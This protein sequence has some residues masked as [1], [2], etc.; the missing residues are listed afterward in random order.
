MSETSGRPPAHNARHVGRLPEFHVVGFSGHRHLADPEGTAGAIHEALAHLRKLI[1]GEWIALSSIARGGDQ[2]FV[3][4]ARRMGLSWHAI[5][6]LAR[7]EFASDFTPEE[8]TDVEKS[9]DT[10]DHVHV[11]DENGDRKDSYLDCGIETVNGSDVLLAVWDGDPARGKGGTAEVVEYARSIGKP[12]VILDPKTLE[13]RRENWDRLEPN[14][15]VLADLNA[16]PDAKSAWAINPFKAPAEVFLFQQK[17]DYH[18]THDAPQ[19]RRLIVATVMAHVLASLVGATVVAYE[20]HSALLALLEL[21]CISFALGAA[22]ALRHKMHSHHSWVRCRLAAEFCRSA[23]ATW[24]LPRAAPLLQDLDVAGARGLTRTLYVMH[25]RSSATRPVP[26]EEFKRIYLEKRVDDQLAYYDRQVNRA[27]PLYKRLAAG[28]SIATISALVSTAFYATSTTLHW[29]I[30]AWI[31]G[32]T[33]VF[34]PIALPALAA[35][36]ISI[37]SINDLQRRVA[38]YREMRQVLQSSRSQVASCRT[39]NSIEHV[40]LKT[41]RALLQEVIEWHS[42]RSF[43]SS[44]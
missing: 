14:D 28:F 38:R 39:W 36:A 25:T 24:G 43:T 42:V 9:L 33:N 10:A 7:V 30:P 22:L 11:V 40:V 32:T 35:A 21:S 17:C 3:N 41:E 8:W 13:V 23:L 4:A 1:P 29:D 20:L 6:P 15:A 5:L 27:L 2:L 44:H 12:I 18:A 19:F 26:M 16:L 31:S 37:I 34:L